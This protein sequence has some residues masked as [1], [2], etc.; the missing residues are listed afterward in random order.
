MSGGWSE[1]SGDSLLNP[2]V[3]RPTGGVTTTGA[4][5]GDWAGQP[6]RSPTLWL[7]E[8]SSVRVSSLDSVIYL[9]GPQ[10]APGSE[11]WRAAW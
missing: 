4:R 7:G 5:L 9:G 1:V 3:F 8:I 11:G 2:G 10:R 6:G